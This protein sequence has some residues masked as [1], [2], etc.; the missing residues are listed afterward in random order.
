MATS[1][2]TIVI[3]HRGSPGCLPESSAVFATLEDAEN[4][5]RDEHEASRGENGTLPED[6]CEWDYEEVAIGELALGPND[7]DAIANLNIPDAVDYLNEHCY[8]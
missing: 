8:S 5:M 4:Y 7:L 2:D 6:G 1:N 3:V